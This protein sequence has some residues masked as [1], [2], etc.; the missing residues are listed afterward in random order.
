MNTPSDS[1][2]SAMT[3]NLLVVSRAYRG[4][5]DRALADLGLSQATAWPI[6]MTGRLGDGVRQGALAEAL[7]IEGPSLVRI[8]DQ[9][10]AAGLMQRKED[11]NDRRAKTLHLTPAGNAQRVQIEALLVQLRRTLFADIDASD[12][13]TALRVLESLKCTLGRSAAMMDTGTPST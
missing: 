11:A 1:D 7:G 8:L 4:V 2:L 12:L 13:K 9:L 5:A 3:A 6:V 10:V